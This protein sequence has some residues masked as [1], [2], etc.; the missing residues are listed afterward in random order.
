MNHR[1]KEI[2]DIFDQLIGYLED[3]NILNDS[4]IYTEKN[5]KKVCIDMREYLVD[6][7]KKTVAKLKKEPIEPP[8]LR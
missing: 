1:R 4:M 2:V 7:L 5:G 6:Y 8:A 3:A